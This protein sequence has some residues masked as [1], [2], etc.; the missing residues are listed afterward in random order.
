MLSVIILTWNSEIHIE[1]CIKSLYIAARD[2]TAGINVYVIDNGSTDKTIYKLNKLK[3][4]YPTLNIVQLEK[5]KGTTFPRN[6]GLR[7]SEGKYVLF[8]DSDTEVFPQTINLLINVIEKEEKVGIAGP[9]LLYPEGDVQYSCKK[10]PTVKSKLL[11]LIPLEKCKELAAQEELYNLNIYRKNFKKIIE[12][13][14]CI[15]AAWMVNRQAIKEVGFFDEKI[16]Y[17]PEDV[18]YC[19]R[20]WLKKWRVVYIPYAKVIHHTQRI[21]YRSPMIA[22]KHIKGLIYFFKKYKYWLKREN[23]YKKIGFVPGL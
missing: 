2:L 23:I 19:L 4:I 21:S 16:F 3:I 20:M 14:Y 10:F 15:S 12:V 9:Q 17:A 5:N 11:K 8:L 13:D 22:L 1:R 18:D 6:I 7:I